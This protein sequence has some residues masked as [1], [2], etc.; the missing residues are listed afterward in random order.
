MSTHYYKQ[1][2]EIPG[3]ALNYFKV[4]SQEE[5][6]QLTTN[7]IEITREEYEM[8][9]NAPKVTLE[10]VEEAI[11][12]ETY[13]VLPNGRTTVCQLTLID[14]GDQGFTV[15]GQSACV[16]R[17]NYN[18]E[19]GN[20]IAR[21]NALNEVWK[22]K[23]YELALELKRQRDRAN[24]TYKERLQRE[25][26]E[27]TQRIGRLESWIDSPSYYQ[28]TLEEQEDQKEQLVLMKSYCHILDRRLARLVTKN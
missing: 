15:E 13:T 5:A 17:A 2:P 7:C 27:L 23:G 16:S 9:T 22:V 20:K 21:E 4:S 19:L 18:E 28:L 14:L 3:A 6:Q 25:F 12:K 26:G 24:E 11:V 8:N 10:Q 1:L